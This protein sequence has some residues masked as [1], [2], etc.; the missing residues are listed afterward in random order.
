MPALL[1]PHL[2]P[3][4][5][6]HIRWGQLYGCSHEWLI[7]QSAQGFDGLL[8]LVVPDVHAAYQAE[9]ALQ[10]FAPDI[11]S[12]IFPDWETLP[13]DVFSPHEDIISERLKTL[14]TLQNLKRGILIVP[15]STLLHRLAP[16]GYVHGHTFV[17]RK[18]SP[19][20]IDKLRKQLEEAG[21][22]NVSQVM[23]HGEYATRGS[24]VDLFPMGSNTPYRLD[25]FDDE[26]DSIRTFNPETQLTEEKVDSIELLPAREFPLD[27]AGIRT[28]RQNYRAQIEGDLTRSR[29]YEGVSQGKPS[30][31]IEYYLPLFFEHTATLFD[32][33]PKKTLLVLTEGVDTA[34]SRFWKSLEDRYEQ[35]RHDIER[36]LLAPEK[37]F[38]TAAMLG[39]YLT[40][41]PRVEAQHRRGVL[42]TPSS[43]DHDAEE[44]RM[45]YAPTVDY[46]VSAL[47]SLLIHARQE[48]PLF[49]LLNFIKD[50][51]G[52]VLFTAESAGRREAFLTL[53][54][55]NG[56]VVKTLETW[57]DFLGSKA[58][59]AVTVAPLENGFWLPDAKIAV[60]PENLLHGVQIQQQRR[61]RKATRDADAIIRN[62]TDLNEGAPVV[63]EEHGVG[64]YL[65]LETVT[66]GGVTA[67]YLL[68]EYANH[69][70]LYVPVAALHLVSRY[71]GADPEHAPLHR[72]GNEQWDK[73]RQK[74]AEKAR[75]VAAELLDI[76]ARRAAQQG[77]SFPFEDNDYRLFAGAFPFEETPD[78]ALAIE[79][80]IKDMR[81]PQPMDRV[82]CGDVGFGKTEVAM[83]AA[84]VAA[85]AGKQVAMIAPTTLLTQ[86]HL[87]NF[88]DRFADWPFN[89]ES[90][91]RFKTGK[92]TSKALEAL[93]SGKIDIVIGTHKL[94]Q[95]DVHFKQL[96]LVIIDEEHRFGVRDK[97]QMKKLRANVDMLTMTATPIPR[98]LN[99][100]LS[101]LRDLSIIA[102]PPT[103]RH[104]IKT[105]VCEW[106]K[107]IIQEACA[108]ELSRG[109]QV[110]VLHNEV[111]TIANVEAELS[112]ML[113]G[114][115]VRHA[116]GQMRAN[117][118]E[119]IM[120]DFYHQ[121]F[122]ILIATTIIESGIDVPTANTI[123]INR[124]DKL[125]LA[126]LHQLRGRVGRS[127]H[128]AY[129]YLIAPPKSALT[130]DAVKRLE[131]IASLEE[132]GVGFTLA[133]HDLEIRGAGE[134]LGEGQS[135]QIQEIGFNLYNDLLERAVKALKSGKVPELSAT[136]RRTTVEL[137]APALIPDAYLPDVHARLI[138]YK[139][140]ASAES[141]A[142]LD[143]LRVE[144]IDRFGLL[145]EPTKTLFSVTRV[146]LL[147][148][149]LGIRKLDMHVKGG[150]I[151]FDD[152][153]NIDPM[154]VITLIQKRPWV[155]K[156]DGQDKLRFE[157][158]LPTVEERE[159]WVVKLMG[160]IGG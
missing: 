114:V 49:L 134:L 123:L 68:I 1:K 67:E 16:P 25:L 53:L 121:R 59:M 37:L 87:N 148:Q 65:G 98:T 71:T 88:L 103:Q 135:G 74:A 17:V 150:R 129:A 27:E 70:K 99:M 29:I 158:E 10:F 117:E 105:F 100:S 104:A 112:A 97:E 75:D 77:H 38:L 36:P 118:L 92:E 58:E 46:P 24:L 61:R 138:L 137:G 19:L 20:D 18:G 42:H 6:G 31:G 109:G 151:I 57:Q 93:A 125:G 43:S 26:I 81:A 120:S 48:Q 4:P 156:L 69:D 32:Y 126:Q 133:T 73:A 60:I 14:A 146:K 91:S 13:Y 54:K 86:Q 7:A 66:A 124:A 113:P 47:P 90:L 155:F 131:A 5:N 15:A 102:T 128:R 154:K 50:L 127:H 23:E 94:L 39:S 79:N 110:Y 22:R 44:G 64:R 89:I 108:R 152:K 80:V 142:A 159:E 41:Y 11:P 82:V 40:D 2:P 35:R 132:L 157:I 140:I 21:Y 115:T 160:E 56:I 144:M 96:G 76:H 63:H 45:Q 143:E 107:T 51:K 8:L 28:F 52:R 136:S 116:H 34:I 153:P 145:P 83:R 101:G 85:N 12:H 55:D 141:Q 139:R 147:A 119:S 130:P 149:E 84:F 78:Q 3:A 72:L 111:K 30:A 106:N 62:L 9:S 33:L 95:D 122:Q